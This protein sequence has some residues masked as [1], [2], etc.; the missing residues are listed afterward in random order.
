LARTVCEKHEPSGTDPLYREVASA[1]ASVDTTRSRPFDEWLKDLLGA[2]SED[3]RV[4]HTNLTL[5]LI[6]RLSPGVADVFDSNASTTSGSLDLRLR[7]NLHEFI[8]DVH[9]DHEV[10][11]Q[12]EFE[13]LVVNLRKTDSRSETR[14]RD[15]AAIVYSSERDLTRVAAW[16][17][18]IDAR[19]CVVLRI[20]LPAHDPGSQLRDRYLA[21]LEAVATSKAEKGSLATALV[22]ASHR[23][24]SSSLDAAGPLE[25]WHEVL[26]ERSSVG[27]RFVLILEFLAVTAED[28]ES[29]SRWLTRD[30]APRHDR[31]IVVAGGLPE[32]SE[33]APVQGTWAYR[34]RPATRTQG[35][36]QPIANDEAR[37]NDLLEMSQEIDAL[38]DAIASTKLTPPLVVG[39]CGGW[40]AGKSFVLDLIE[41]RLREIRSAE[42]PRENPLHVGHIYWI[43]FDAW[44]Y[45]KKNLWAS[46]MD[47]ICRQFEMQLNVERIQFVDEEK[48]EEERR[49]PPD[50]PPW[51][52]SKAL[53][54]ADPED[55]Q[56]YNYWS[57]TL[58]RDSS[59]L[60]ELLVEFNERD[61][62]EKKEEL[63][64]QLKEAQA[65]E[66][67]L[68]ALHD[69]F[70]EEQLPGRV[71]KDFLDSIPAKLLHALGVDRS[72]L[73]GMQDVGSAMRVLRDNGG[74]AKMLLGAF[75]SP[76]VVP[77]A[78]IG[79]GAFALE[80]M[81]DYEW[82]LPVGLLSVLSSIGLAIFRVADARDK[83]NRRIA[84]GQAE[85]DRLREEARLKLAEEYEG[86]TEYENK[87]EEQRDQQEN[88]QSE[89]DQHISELGVPFLELG[90][91]Q[92]FLEDIRGGEEYTR[93]LGLMNLVQSHLQKLSR[94]VTGWGARRS[95]PAANKGDRYLPFRRGLPR[96]VLKIDDLD[97]CP[98]R[99]VVEVLEAAQ[100]LV[101]TDLFV[102][103]LAI[104]LR[105]VTRAIERRYDGILSHDEHP[106][107]LDYIEKII[108]LPYR[109]RPIAE[110]QLESFFGGQLEVVAKKGPKKDGSKKK[111]TVAPLGD[112]PARTIRLPK[113][114]LMEEVLRLGEDEFHDVVNACRPLDLSPRAGKRIGNVYKI[115]KLLWFKRGEDDDT[116]PPKLKRAMVSLLA[117]STVRPRL[118]RHGLR[119]LTQWVRDDE[120]RLRRADGLF[121]DLARALDEPP[122][123]Q[124]LFEGDSPYLGSVQV[125]E[126]SPRNLSLLT[127]FSFVGDD[128]SM[129]K[130]DGASPSRKEPLSG[131]PPPPEPEEE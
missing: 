9:A 122:H 6:A 28:V 63:T 105:Y 125:R 77:A 102:V 91:L 113:Q 109:V 129:R 61:F 45:S 98:P 130:E 71:T 11:S 87:L 66:E 47:Q 33:I 60:P 8:A 2:C 30:V 34:L 38:A 43:E 12:G 100:L 115:W 75:R 68:V 1:L 120:R 88:L 106:T 104:D 14:G 29:V 58:G 26:A 131:E 73:R 19:N 22:N 85:L 53:S 55:L 78:L 24:E 95:D 79:L 25:A 31:L 4:L 35:I 110:D 101:K 108:Q 41:R 37:G 21:R 50:L 42:V 5:L 52:V 7:L 116:T 13:E 93:R 126:F 111:Q 117:L 119:A 82:S 49:I 74:A 46:L 127:S 123:I 16:A 36:S 59:S 124:R 94:L 44:T 32:D 69:E 15:R 97:R 27:H 18:E 99:K 3:V 76:Y 70:I 40:G 39:I 86:N 17:R 57:A 48:S 118:A 51:T 62:H 128:D 89:L 121:L 112:I 92:K 114:P 10:V 80:V 54:G 83:V 103:L 23:M 72:F 65:E 84:R 20:P 90:D 64:S 107:G 67:R 56:N 96:I 81:R